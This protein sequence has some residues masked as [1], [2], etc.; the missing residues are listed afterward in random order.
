MRNGS[1]EEIFQGRVKDIKKINENFFI[2]KKKKLLTLILY[3][4]II[5]S[6][7]IIYYSY[8]SCTSLPYKM[9]PRVKFDC[10]MLYRLHK[11]ENGVVRVSST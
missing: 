5:Y 7:Y 4:I 8:P 9:H 2:K 6:F 11:R 10:L 1:L 3:E